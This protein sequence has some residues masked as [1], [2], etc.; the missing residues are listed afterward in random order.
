MLFL[1][2]QAN[3]RLNFW[4][5]V[6]ARNCDGSADSGVQLG[7]RPLIDLLYGYPHESDGVPEAEQ[8]GDNVGD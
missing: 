1:V 2:E 5:I 8:L 3:S 6:W 7:H 4:P